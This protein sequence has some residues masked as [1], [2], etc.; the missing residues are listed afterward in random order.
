MELFTCKICSFEKEYDDAPLQC[1][2][3]N[4]AFYR[5]TF[6]KENSINRNKG[7]NWYEKDN[8]RWSWS[9]GVNVQDIPEMTKKYPDRKYHHKTGQLLVRNRAHKKKLMKEHGMHELC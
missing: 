1:P 2:K 3:C 5:I 4:R 7:V 8:P 9:M 6:L